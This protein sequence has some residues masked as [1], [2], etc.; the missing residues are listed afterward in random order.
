MVG[1]GVPTR[2]TVAGVVAGGRGLSLDP[3]VSLVDAVAF[4]TG[5]AAPPVPTTRL[6]IPTAA[7]PLQTGSVLA[8]AGTVALFALFVSLTGFIAARNVLGD[9]SPVKAL[10]LGPIPAVLAT[11]PQAFGVS[12]AVVVVVALLADWAGVYYLYE[13]SPRLAAYVTFIHAVVTIILGAV[14]FGLL[15]LFASAPG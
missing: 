3:V 2:D 4:A 7:V 10:G 6:W 8:I 11:L 5:S 15:A 13:R 12:P 1:V 14:L 9:V